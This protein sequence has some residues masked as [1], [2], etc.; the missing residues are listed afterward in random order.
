MENTTPEFR[1][2][3]LL[4]RLGWRLATA[5][6]CT[7]GLIA[8]RL[9]NVPGSSDYY[10]GG[11]IAYANELKMG[12]LG[13]RPTTLEQFGAVSRETVLEMA[14]GVRQRLGAQV[15]LSVSGIAGP[16]GGTDEK[17]VGLVWIGLSAPGFEHPWRYV[18]EGDRVQVKEQTA[19]EALRLLVEYLASQ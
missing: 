7:G 14:Y 5:E 15:G 19:E 1:I 2:G 12:L 18:W 4:R 10:L 13:V 11:V 6:S 16:G 8:H 3:A 9:T 17:P